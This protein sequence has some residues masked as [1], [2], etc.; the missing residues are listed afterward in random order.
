M[1]APDRCCCSC[2]CCNSSDEN[3]NRNSSANV[4]FW[5][6]LHA[7]FPKLMPVNPKEITKEQ[8]EE[9]LKS[10]GDQSELGKLFENIKSEKK[11]GNGE[12]KSLF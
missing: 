1:E 2:S 12:H 7:K 8:Y 5:K 10:Y 4:K 11:G 3:W 6:E 9:N